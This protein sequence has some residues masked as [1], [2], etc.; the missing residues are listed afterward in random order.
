MANY[1]CMYGALRAQVSFG[2]QTTYPTGCTS[3]DIK[4]SQLQ[5]NYMVGVCRSMLCFGD[6][7]KM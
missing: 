1:V 6:L 3:K 5:V 4:Q 2:V 7:S